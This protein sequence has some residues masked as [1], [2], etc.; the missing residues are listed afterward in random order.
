[1]GPNIA[2]ALHYKGYWAQPEY[3]S[4]DRVFYGKISGIR[5][6]VDFQTENAEVLEG[7]FRKAVDDY[8]AFCADI[9]K[10]PDLPSEKK[11]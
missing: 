3:S 1:M 4:E 9:G 2:E 6:L 10:E 11:E 7:E 5:D 8:L